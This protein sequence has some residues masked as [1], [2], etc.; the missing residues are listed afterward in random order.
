MNDNEQSDRFAPILKELDEDERQLLAKALKH[1]E[2]Q[3]NKNTRFIQL[4]Q[5]HLFH[6]RTLAKR[7][8]A[9][10]TV[11][12]AMVECMNK[13]NVLIAT[14]EVIASYSDY[15]VASVKKALKYLDQHNWIEIRKIGNIRAYA[16]NSRVFWK[17]TPHGRQ[18]AF[19]ATVILSEE[20]QHELTRKYEHPLNHIPILQKPHTEQTLIHHDHD[21]DQQELDV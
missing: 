16:I 12:M 10:H 13:T 5:S 3:E 17:S 7:E 21:T 8:P 18:A 19:N 6:L 2:E 4:A 11:L 14:Q 1:I 9:A 20:D 15:S